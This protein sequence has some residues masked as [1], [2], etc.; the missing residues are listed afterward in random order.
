MEGDVLYAWLAAI[1]DGEGSIMLTRRKEGGDTYKKVRPVVSVSNTDVRLMDALKERTG[2]GSVYL[3]R[4]AP[5]ENQ[6]RDGYTWRLNASDQR[7]WI[8]RIRPFL[9]LKGEQADLL[10]E[11]LVLRETRTSVSGGTLVLD[12]LDRLF[13][14]QAE[15]SNL[16][17]KGREPKK[18]RE[19]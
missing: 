11:A 1:I 10:M 17:R 7:I 2:T 13:E 12:G 8:P 14:I 18:G 6:K 3:H 5:K 19:A 9:V 4:R 16:N 15:I